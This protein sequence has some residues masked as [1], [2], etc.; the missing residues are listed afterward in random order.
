MIV[1]FRCTAETK[2]HLD[3]LLNTG[4]Y[5]SYDEAIAAAVRN[6]VLMEQE[7]GEKG[8][9]VIGAAA[10]A[11]SPP[12]TY[13]PSNGQLELKLAAKRTGNG[14]PGKK[15]PATLRCA[16]PLALEIPALFRLEGFPQ[17]APQG[18]A[19]LPPDMWSDGQ[20]IPLD[21]WVLGQFNRLL[22][23]KVNARALIRLFLD[24][25]KGLDIAEAATTVAAQAAVL[26]DYLRHIDARHDVSRDDLVSTAFP[27]SGED[28]EK[29]RTRYANQFVV[30]QNTKG[31]LSGLMID[32][33]LINVL[34]HRKERRVVPTRVAWEFAA[35]RNPL[36]DGAEQG[37]PEKFTPPE[38]SFLLGHIVRSV[39]VEAFAYGVILEAVQRGQTSPE[40][41]DAAM[42][43]YLDEDRVGD[44]SQSF[45]AS[46]RSGAVSRMSDLGLIERRRE[47]VRVFYAATED[48]LAF[49]R[50]CAANQPR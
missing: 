16:E 42:K 45:L 25:P 28:S 26:G 5:K 9:I 11:P 36:L 49:L 30:Y 39:P 47:G 13:D 10:A 20:K 24:S 46:Q 4:A 1:C 12:A 8:A 6:Q 32:L 17:D 35:M 44:L 14:V 34:L 22:P 23:A 37:P 48:G 41:I 27:T 2:A 7:V 31:E 33:K 50:E 43:T 15:V 18:L 40:Q 3:V 29:S 19:D 21:R 38:R